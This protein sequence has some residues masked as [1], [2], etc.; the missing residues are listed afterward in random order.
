ML[1]ENFA[2]LEIYANYL[3][4]KENGRKLFQQKVFPIRKEEYL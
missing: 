4:I 1:Y 3:S 2:H